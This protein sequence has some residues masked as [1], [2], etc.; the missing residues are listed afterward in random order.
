MKMNVNLSLLLVLLIGLLTG[1]AGHTGVGSAPSPQP[2]AA[3]SPEEALRARATQFWEARVKGD[4]ATQYDL[5]EPKGREQVTLT[6]FFH[7]RSRV[8]F[9]SYEIQ[10]VEVDGE[11]G[12]VTTKTRFRLNLPTVSRYGPWDQVV[13]M[14]WV[15][16]NGVWYVEYDQ[17]DI[18]PPIQSGGMRS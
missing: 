2:G 15:R 16:V 5:L 8:V 12:V 10:Q 1:C 18:K 6:G 3:Q 13:V 14:R 7:A 11:R 9:Q 17:G 4:L